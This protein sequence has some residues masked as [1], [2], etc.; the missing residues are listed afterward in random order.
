MKRF[1][2]IVG[3]IL[4]TLIACGFNIAVAVVLWHFV[5]KFW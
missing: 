4:V 3:L 5:M 1:L 2:T